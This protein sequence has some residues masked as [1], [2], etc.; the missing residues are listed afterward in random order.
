ME[1]TQNAQA[2]P[3]AMGLGEKLDKAGWGIALIWIGAAILLNLGWSIG[4]F[5]LGAITLAGQQLRRHFSLACDGFAMAMG[6]CLVL[7]GM[8][9]VLGDR[10]GGAALLPVMSIALGIIF[11]ATALLRKQSA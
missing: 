7:V 8:G 2:M 11:L 6:I 4:L 5:G 3:S 10:L 9:P 1:Q